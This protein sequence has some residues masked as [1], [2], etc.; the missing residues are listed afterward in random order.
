MVVKEAPI[1]PRGAEI[2][3]HTVVCKH[4]HSLSI[5]PEFPVEKQK[6]VLYNLK[7]YS[8]EVNAVIR[9]HPYI[10]LASPYVGMSNIFVIKFIEVIE[11]FRKFLGHV[12]IAHNEFTLLLILKI[13]PYY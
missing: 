2:R 6:F 1:Q 12:L 8:L 13:L 10:S 3:P 5:L 9:S 4:K 7:D 11:H